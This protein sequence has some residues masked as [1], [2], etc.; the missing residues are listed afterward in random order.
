MLEDR[1][2]WVISF[3]KKAGFLMSPSRAYFQITPQGKE[4]LATGTDHLTS[5]QW[6]DL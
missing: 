5:L 1:M 4:I 6:K 3:L 2:S